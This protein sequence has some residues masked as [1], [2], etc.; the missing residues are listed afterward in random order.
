MDGFTPKTFAIES[1]VECFGL[2]LLFSIVQIVCLLTFACFARSST[3]SFL[4]TRSSFNICPFIQHVRQ[5]QLTKSVSCGL[6][7]V[8]YKLPS[9]Y[10]ALH[11]G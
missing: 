3:E 9:V 10:Y 11:H 4:A 1:I 6:P 8:K 7:H 5:L 2:V